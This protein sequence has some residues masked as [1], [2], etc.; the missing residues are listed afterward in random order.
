MKNTANS[1]FK[2]LLIV[3]I[4]LL[5]LFVT[6]KIFKGIVLIIAAI[7]CVFIATITMLIVGRKLV[8]KERDAYLYAADRR[9]PFKLN[10]LKVILGYLLIFSPIWLIMSLI[11]L[12]TP[13]V[14]WA[15]TLPLIGGTY[16]FLAGKWKDTWCE[17]E[18]KT[19]IYF[20]FHIVGIVLMLSIILLIKTLL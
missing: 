9:L 2:Y 8:V 4:N 15:Y 18:F 19:Y 16:L 17:L 5:V 11:F 7:V 14:T 6:F 13:N 3:P 20:L 12:L 10:E 1:L